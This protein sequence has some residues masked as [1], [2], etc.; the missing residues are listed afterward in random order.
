MQLDL[1]FLNAPQA[2]ETAPIPDAAA[3]AAA[4]EILARILAKAL[5][6]TPRSRESRDE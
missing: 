4:L 1:A 6:T 2:R 5:E 3:R